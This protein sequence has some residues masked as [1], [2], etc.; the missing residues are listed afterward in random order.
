MIWK[1]Y[2]IEINFGQKIVMKKSFRQLDNGK[3]NWQNIELEKP[4]YNLIVDY[5]SSVQ[6]KTG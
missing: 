1:S 5:E 3:Q 4:R 2:H 6:G